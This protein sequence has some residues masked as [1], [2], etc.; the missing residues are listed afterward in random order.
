MGDR[1]PDPDAYEELKRK[2]M[3]IYEAFEVGGIEDVLYE[4]KDGKYL[5]EDMIAESL[6]VEE[7]MKKDRADAMRIGVEMKADSKKLEA[8][9]D[10][11]LQNMFKVKPNQKPKPKT[12][13]VNKK[14]IEIEPLQELS[15]ALQ[16]RVP[17]L[18]E[19]YIPDEEALQIVKL[20]IK[21]GDLCQLVGKP[22]VGK[23]SLINYVAAKYN[24]PLTRLPANGE[25]EPSDLLGSLVVEDGQLV[26][27][28]GIVTQAVQ[29]P[30]ILLID[31]VYKFNPAT[32]MCL[33]WLYEENGKLVLH[34]K[35]GTLE[36]KV[37]KPHKD[38]RI[39]LTD[40]VK[41]LGDN[42]AEFSATNLQDT[43]QL[44]RV[45]VTIEMDYLPPEKEK[46]VLSKWFPGFGTDYIVDMIKIAGLIRRAKEKGEISL[47]ISLGR[48]LK[49]WCAYT[50]DLVDIQ[51][52]FKYTYLNKLSDESEKDCVRELFKQVFNYDYAY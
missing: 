33:Q 37:I 18:D 8:L 6:K 41:G 27:K 38:F 22:G 15:P 39:F 49:S 32:A 25:L 24:Y 2:F 7:E 50:Q 19:S 30:G 14:Q 47:G 10:D 3:D 31:E 29:N 35:P 16:L 42:L 23:T 52:A 36:D 40:N 12:T 48:G 11:V 51:L 43:S 34:D 5:S 4:P 21:N 9:A 17:E 13:Q 44:D 46:E 28:D 45:K 26:W 20:A 1:C